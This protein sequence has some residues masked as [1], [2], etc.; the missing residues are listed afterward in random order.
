MQINI[1]RNTFT[2]LISQNLIFSIDVGIL[3]E[4]RIQGHRSRDGGILN[5]NVPTH[6]V[7]AS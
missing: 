7:K 4:S 1:L 6:P 5:L 3:T 2:L